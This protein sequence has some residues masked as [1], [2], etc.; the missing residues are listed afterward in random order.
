[1]VQP[2]YVT[3]TATSSDGT[4]IQYQTIGHQGPW[5]IAASSLQAGTNAW[6]YVASYFADQVR[7][8]TWN[9]RGLRSDE[10]CDPP[11]HYQV[12]L[13]TH[14]ADLVSILQAENA[15]GGVWMGW[16]FGAQVV[17]HA[18]SQQQHL[19]ERTAYPDQIVLI[20]PC[21]GERSV[22]TSKARRLL[23]YVVS[24]L[25]VWPSPAQR[26][27]NRVA[28]WPETGPWLKRLRLVADGMDE[29][30]ISE[31]MGHLQNLNVLAYLHAIGERAENRMD[32]ILPTVD[33]PT[34]VIIGDR[35]LVTPRSVAEP[36]TRQIPGV[37]SFV[38]RSATHFALLEF[39]E[40]INLR[41]EKFLREQGGLMSY[42]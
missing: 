11:C 19:Q 17:L 25:E 13:A 20:A 42:T 5:V 29:D 28:G 15:T 18:L 23:P 41:V 2:D 8:L 30:S 33:R 26:I 32:P 35:D 16:G 9:Y 10:P 14:S 3:K 34:L 24:A 21:F 7:L 12:S 39:P 36:L 27:A 6:K 22:I 38:V 40:L 1:M 4:R 31:T 37:E